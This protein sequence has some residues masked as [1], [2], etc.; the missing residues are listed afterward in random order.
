[1]SRK[2][3][4]KLWSLYHVTLDAQ[5]RPKYNCY[6]IYNNGRGLWSSGHFRDL[7]F[8]KDVHVTFTSKWRL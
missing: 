3:I 6:I 4:A 2:E 8:A 1:M 7:D 5:V